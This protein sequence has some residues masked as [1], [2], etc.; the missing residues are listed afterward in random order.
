VSPAVSRWFSK[1]TDTPSSIK[2]SG[3]NAFMLGVFTN[4]EPEVLDYLL[5]KSISP[6]GHDVARG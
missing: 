1:L 6:A 5:A 2:F 4:A 3:F